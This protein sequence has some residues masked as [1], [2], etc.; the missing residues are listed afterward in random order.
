MS[1][2]AIVAAIALSSVA[3][4]VFAV[5]AVCDASILSRSTEETSSEK[6]VRGEDI[7]SDVENET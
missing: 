2:L 6:E 4:V 1:K 5:L 7:T 3:M